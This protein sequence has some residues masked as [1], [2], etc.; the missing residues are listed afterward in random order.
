MG[1]CNVYFLSLDGGYDYLLLYSLLYVK[2]LSISSRM[3]PLIIRL[4]LLGKSYLLL[5]NFIGTF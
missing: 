1:F 2:Y 3:L 5:Y 4:P